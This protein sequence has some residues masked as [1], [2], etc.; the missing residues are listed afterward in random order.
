MNVVRSL[1]S[2]GNA[3]ALPIKVLKD[4]LRREKSDM[5]VLPPA[6]VCVSGTVCPSRDE[7]QMN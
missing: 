6:W 2:S 1:P 3:R 5:M 4:R 7:H